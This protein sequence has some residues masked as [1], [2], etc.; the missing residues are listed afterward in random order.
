MAALTFPAVSPRATAV[1]EL[2]IPLPAVI[3]LAVS[4]YLIVLFFL[5]LIHQCLQARDCCPSCFGWQKVGELGLCDMCIS[6]AQTCDCRMPSPAHV[7]DSCCP[8][9]P[10]CPSCSGLSCCPLC[11]FACTYQPPDCNPIN[12][13]CCEIK[14]R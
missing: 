3:L 13:I 14:L 4:L 10:S 9:N 5:L 6:C 12:C 2:S 11:D 7:M 1:S 8:S